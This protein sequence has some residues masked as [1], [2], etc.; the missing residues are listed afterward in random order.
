M[1]LMGHPERYGVIRGTW[2]QQL[3]PNGEGICSENAFWET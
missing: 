1:E 2:L 3:R